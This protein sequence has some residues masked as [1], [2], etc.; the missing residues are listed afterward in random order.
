MMDLPHFLD[1]LWLARFVIL[2]GL[3]V[4]VS[5]SLLAILLGSLLGVL[6]GLSLVYGNR[7]LRFV[8]R[9]YTDLIRGTPVLVLVL[10]LVTVTVACSSAVVPRGYGTYLMST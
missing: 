3:G 2:K 1:Q 4:T 7:L 5:I 6:V 9:V 8:M 10:V